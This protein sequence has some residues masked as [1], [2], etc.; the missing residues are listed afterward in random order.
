MPWAVAAAAVVAGA[1]VYSSNQQKK[2]AKKASRAQ[3]SS[4][5][6]GIEEQRRQFDTVR[7]LLLPYVEGGKG[8]MAAQQALLGLSGPDAQREAIAGIEASPAFAA[9]TKQGETSILQ[10]AAATGGLRGGNVQGALAQ[11]RPALLAQLI[12]QRFSNLGELTRVGQASAA[13]QA[14]FG[15]QTSSN[16]GGFLGQIGQAQAGQALA[17]GQANA[18]LAS[19]LGQAL[20]TYLGSQSGSGGLFGGTSGGTAGMK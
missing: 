20:S 17:T 5:E 3:T 13:G 6:A 9:L 8:A 4:A 19:G 12:E 18:Q 1:S 10:N 11:F 7:E 15:Q 16:I 2:A 14:A